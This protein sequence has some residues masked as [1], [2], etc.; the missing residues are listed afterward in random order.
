ML[1]ERRDTVADGRNDG[2]E[3]EEHVDVVALVLGDVEGRR[4]A[5]L[6]GHVLRCPACRREYDEVASIVGDLLP[7]VPAVQPPLGFD[8]HA[9]RRL[10]PAA[11]PARS[12]RPLLAATAA[13]ALVVA[14]VLAWWAFSAGDTSTE[15]AT[16]HLTDGGAPTGTVSLS[17]V[18]GDS[19]MVVAIVDAPPGISYFCRTVLADGTTVDSDSWPAG[20]GAWIVP[21][22]ADADVATVEIIPAGTDH[23]WSTATFE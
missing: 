9:L 6:A 11:S 5:E 23:V 17:D 3:D 16:L 7:A 4:R 8:E 15:L 18:E 10:G 2:L 1:T 19:L 12:R 22:P 13:V 20:D 21:L 14:G